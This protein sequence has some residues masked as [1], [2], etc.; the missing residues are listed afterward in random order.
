MLNNHAPNARNPIHP[1][2]EGLVQSLSIEEGE[3]ANAV[4]A[5]GEQVSSPARLLKALAVIDL[6]TLSGDDTPERVKAL[7]AKARQPLKPEVQAK[8]GAEGVTTAAVCVYH[9]FIGTALEALK[10]ALPLAV[11]SAGFPHG[12]SPLKARILEVEES[13]A[14]GAT[15]IDIVIDRSKALT[16]DWKGV[17]DE[18]RAFRQA[19]GEAHMKAIIATGDLGS[20]GNVAKASVVCMM[21]GADFIKTSTGKEAVNAT[22]NVALVMAQMIALWLK[23][24]GYKVGFKPAGGISKAKDALVYQAIM[25][26]VLGEEW[27]EPHLFRIGASSLLGDIVTQLENA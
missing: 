24:T 5:L 7:C 15:E 23:K 14:A 6:T 20:L 10:G 4:A 3:V 26:D 11:V 22:P 19:C 1:Y 9:A 17:Y 18:V 21:A 27:L 12:L 16:G 25:Q 8:L 2:D 13:V